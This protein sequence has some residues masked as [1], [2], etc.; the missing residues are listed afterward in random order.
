MGSQSGALEVEF[1]KGTLGALSCV[2]MPSVWSV[3]LW[4][5]LINHP[6][7]RCN[8]NSLDGVGVVRLYSKHEGDLQVTLSTGNRE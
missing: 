7:L 2:F 1:Y 4:W 8:I 3:G 6:C 5:T